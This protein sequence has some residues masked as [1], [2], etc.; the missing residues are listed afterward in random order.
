[1]TQMF[2]S[3]GE[4]RRRA[5]GIGV[6]ILIS[7]LIVI[8]FLLSMNLGQIRLTPGE[9]LQTLIGNGTPKQE[10][11]LFEFR[12]PQ[13][14]IA[15]LVG[16]GLAVSGCLLQGVTGNSLAEPGILGINS[17]AGLAV[18][19]F[20]YFYPEELLGSVYLMPVLALAGAGVTAGV[21]FYL[22]Y[23]RGEGVSAIRLVLAGIGVAAGINALT[24]VLSLRL[25]PQSHQFIYTWLA[26]TIRG[27][28][29]T[30]VM[31]FL[32]WLLVLIPYAV[33]KAKVL[34]ILTLGD[35]S[36]VGLGTAVQKERFIMMGAAVALAGACVAVGGAISFVG[37]IS[38]HLA[39]RL[40]GPKHQLLLPASMLCGGL[41]MIVAD[42]ITR[43]FVASASI[44]IGV[45]VAVIGAPY[46]LYL[47]AK[48]RS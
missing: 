33:Y 12:L 46:F 3:Q 42:A 29:W 15:I 11:I 16:A 31:A 27:T 41:L 47:L 26:G 28:N 35:S 40:V 2:T 4:K 34:N 8:L 21:I 44:P 48:S 14:I 45:V 1:M 38:P 23:K 6:M 20:V 18:L 7:A 9:V 37:L 19:V 13:I 24:M 32:P 5:R 22:A 10:L 39:R 43:A 36:A 30:Y 25:D 17:G